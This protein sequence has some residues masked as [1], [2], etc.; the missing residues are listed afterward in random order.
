MPSI[1]YLGA[2]I[3]DR[4]TGA[5]RK[6]ICCARGTL[7]QCHEA[8]NLL[9]WRGRDDATGRSTL[10][11]VRRE[12]RTSPRCAVSSIHMSQGRN[13]R[14]WALAPGGEPGSDSA[15]TRAVGVALLSQG[16]ARKV[17]VS[18]VGDRARSREHGE[19]GSRAGSGA[20]AREFTAALEAIERIGSVRRIP[21]VQSA[22]CAPS[23]CAIPR[24]RGRHSRR[25]S[26]FQPGALRA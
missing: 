20:L 1:Y 13:Q 14:R 23:V 24:R 17:S 8:A 22:R 18:W 11:A 21:V 26:G 3:S 12:T 9:R 2:S 10:Q 15:R 25:R 6:A 4:A 16:R 7:S 5:R 19:S